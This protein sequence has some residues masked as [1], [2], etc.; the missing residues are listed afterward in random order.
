M[1]NLYKD[2]PATSFV[3]TEEYEE[4]RDINRIQAEF[5]VDILFFQLILLFT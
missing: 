4:F 1:A 3:A 5:L 2:V